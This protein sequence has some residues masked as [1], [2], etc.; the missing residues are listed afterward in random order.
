MLCKKILEGGITEL[1]CSNGE[2]IAGHYG[3]ELNCLAAIQKA[4]MLEQ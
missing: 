1:F 4:L 2:S 3:G